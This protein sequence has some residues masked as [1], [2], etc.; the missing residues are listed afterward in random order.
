MDNTTQ[1]VQPMETEAMTVE[2]FG[3]QV[4]TRIGFAERWLHRARA[5]CEDGNVTAGLLTMALADA[6]LR[7]ALEASGRR[8]RATGRRRPAPE[9]AGRSRLPWLLPIVAAGAII[10][11]M[12]R[13]M[14]APVGAGPTSGPPV[15]R[16]P[17][18]VGALLATVTVASGQSAP[19][20]TARFIAPRPV[21]PGRTGRPVRLVERAPVPV[22]VQ[23]AV[24]STAATTAVTGPTTTS[25]VSV[26]TSTVPSAPVISDVDLIE[27]V[28]AAD[29]T[30]RGTSP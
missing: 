22:S 19:A 6:E 29:R 28:L 17:S 14:P 9:R 12:I 3:E 16:L 2:V 27:M 21:R 11:W 30:L 13:P 10:V 5:Q 15:V 20:A 18:D 4:A 1:F 24:S 8:M 25:P 7:Y 23:P 26:H